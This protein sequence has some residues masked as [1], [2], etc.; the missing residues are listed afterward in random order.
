MIDWS[1]LVSIF[2]R[3]RNTRPV[4][5]LPGRYYRIRRGNSDT[6]RAFEV[7]TTVETPNP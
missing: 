4:L 5:S 2:S 7:A 6:P 1:L 3:I